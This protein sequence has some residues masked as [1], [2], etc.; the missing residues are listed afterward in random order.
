MIGEQG[1]SV[2]R[3]GTSR[4]SRATIDGILQGKRSLAAGW[5]AFVV[6][7]L[8]QGTTCGFA[9]L[10]VETNGHRG[11]F[12][13]RGCFHAALRFEIFQQQLRLRDLPITLLRLPPELQAM[14]LDQEQLERIVSPKRLVCMIPTVGALRLSHKTPYFANTSLR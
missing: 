5:C 6:A 14:H 3:H 10:A 9:A 2:A 7:E 4:R 11:R 12:S 13:R 1:P 8:R